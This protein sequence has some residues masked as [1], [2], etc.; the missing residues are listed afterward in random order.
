MKL[1]ERIVSVKNFFLRVNVM[2]LILLMVVALSSLTEGYKHHLFDNWVAHTN[3]V[4][5][6]DAAKIE[7]NSQ[8]IERLKTV[9]VAKPV[10]TT[11]APV[12]IVEKVVVPVKTH[13]HPAH[14]GVLKKGTPLSF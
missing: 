6:V 8:E 2:G 10:S 7:Q 5:T 9:V 13:T 1:V 14:H 4:S 11:A 12:V 3:A